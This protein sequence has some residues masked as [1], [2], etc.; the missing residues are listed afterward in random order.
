[1]PIE[2]G[3]YMRH[4]V[5]FNMILIQKF[6]FLTVMRA[7]SRNF[8]LNRQLSPLESKQVIGL[9]HWKCN[10]LPFLEIMTDRPTNGQTEA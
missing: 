6:V 5:H 4:R 8:I 10:F 9:E 7:M 3:V 2:K 1:M